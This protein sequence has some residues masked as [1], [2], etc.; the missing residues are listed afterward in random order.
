MAVILDEAGA[1]VLDEAAADIYDEAGQASVFLYAVRDVR[2]AAPG[3]QGCPE[4]P[5]GRHHQRHRGRRV[6]RH[7]RDVPPRES[8]YHQQVGVI[9]QDVMFVR[10]RDAQHVYCNTTQPAGGVGSACR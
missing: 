3:R 8:G 6:R 4:H 5:A 9:Y 10:K 1:P 7:H 2:A